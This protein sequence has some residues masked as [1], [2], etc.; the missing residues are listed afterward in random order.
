VARGPEPAAAAAPETVAPA[1]GGA[2]PAGVAVRPRVWLWLL[3]AAGL[4]AMLAGAAVL[5]WIFGRGPGASVAE[6]A[7]PAATA[8]ATAGPP[9]KPDEARLVVLGAPWGEV[10]AIRSG[11][12]AAAALPARRTTPLVLT[13]PPGTYTLTLTHPAATAPVDCEVVVATGQAA[14]CQAQLVEVDVMQYFKEAGWWQ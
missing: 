7:Q 4:V 8:A 5:W 12:G 14:T 11:D 1:L 3:L 13:L 9:V 6:D 10:T 2:A